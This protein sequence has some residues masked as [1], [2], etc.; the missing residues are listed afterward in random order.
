MMDL[1]VRV[2]AGTCLSWRW[3]HRGCRH[4]VV[5]AAVGVGGFLSGHEGGSAAIDA[6]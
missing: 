5:L 4:L 6:Q 2:Y 3:V 1:G